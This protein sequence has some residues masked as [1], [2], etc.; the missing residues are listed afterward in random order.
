VDLDFFTI[1]GKGISG[2]LKSILPLRNKIKN[3][4]Y[5]L[6]HAHYALTGWIALLARPTK[7]LVVSYMGSD[8]YGD[9]NR[10]GKIKISSYRDIL[11]AKLL[12]P[13]TNAIIVKSTR[14]QKYIY[15]KRKSHIVANGVNFDRFKPLNMQ[16]C[17]QKLNLP[18]K[19]KIVLFLGD[20]SLPRKNV[21][22]VKNAISKLN[23]RDVLFLC[24]FPV[25][26]EDVP[27]YLNAADVLTLASYLE[28]SPNIV[29]EA[30]ACN[31][32]I[33]ATDSGDVSEIITY[34][35]GCYLSSFEID[36]Y[37]DKIAKALE[38]NART[39]GRNNIAHLNE[40]EVADKLID[41]YKGVLRNK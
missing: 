5:D 10:Q 15:L 24:P 14:L 40:N 25:K 1:R 34:T 28:G 19:K 6:I 13:F 12:Q 11:M 23:R 4:E 32:P 22:L 38:F 31:T 8:T 39:N 26:A 21:I 18:Q 3:S 30:M 16:N 37:A 9:V 27:T 17:R 36:D 2:Y 20:P 41:I 35:K 29:K 7:S 33:V